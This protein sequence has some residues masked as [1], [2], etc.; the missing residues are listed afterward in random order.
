MR[1]ALKKAIS[2]VNYEVDIEDEDDDLFDDD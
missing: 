2:P 1:K